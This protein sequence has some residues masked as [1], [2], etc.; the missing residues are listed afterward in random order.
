M[1]N[2]QSVRNRALDLEAKV[3]AQPGFILDYKIQF[4]GSSGFAE[5]VY[6]KGATLHGVVYQDISAQ[7]M[8]KLDDIER[9][10][11]RKQ[12][13][14]H[15]YNNNNNNNHPPSDTTIVLENVGVYCR[16][17]E[18]I[19]RTHTLQLDQPPSERYMQILTDGAKHYGVD[20]AYIEFLQTHKC[21]P[22]PQLSEYISFFS[23]QDSDNGKR[24][25]GGGG[26]GT[27]N[28]Q[29]DDTNDASTSHDNNIPND[30]FMTR[31]QVLSNGNGRDGNPLC[32][33]CRGLVL[34][35]CSDGGQVDEDFVQSFAATFEHV[36][37][38][39]VE[40]FMC[41]LMYDP[42]W[43]VPDSLEQVTDEHS[44]YMEH[45]LCEY[46]NGQNLLRDKWKV[47]AR[48]KDEDSP[49]DE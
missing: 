38:Q 6:E 17:P 8:L 16:T 11:Q 4:Y 33:I 15:L 40:M 30:K 39:D 21:R 44:A 42:K 20:P 41:R 35:F 36:Q 49:M 9:D 27:T 13:T 28:H 3:P 7:D 47:V 2:P 32:M 1:M 22:R 48:I 18:E 31:Q 12:V 34:Q 14:A 46:L 45:Q 23:S 25:C 10:Y 29:K 37:F 43:G 5:A 24:S 26:G 19:E